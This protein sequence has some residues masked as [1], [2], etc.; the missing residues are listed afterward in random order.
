LVIYQERAL[1]QDFPLLAGLPTTAEPDT[2]SEEDLTSLDAT[3]FS[4]A[5]VFATDWTA[6]TILRQLDKGNISLDP[7]Y[8]R[9]DAWRPDRKSRFIESL[10]LGLPIPQLVLAE[11]KGRK[12]SY[13]VIDGKQRLLSLRQFAAKPAKPDAPY[14]GLSLTGLKIRPELNG[15]TLHDME[16]DP[17][18][19]SEVSAFQ[20]QPIRT[21]VLRNWPDENFLY[22][23]FLRLNTG[24][25]QLSPQ[26]LRQALHPGPFV[27]FSVE[28]S[29]QSKGLQKF[30]RITSPDFRMRDVEM[31]VRFYAFQNFI[32]HYTGNLKVFMDTTCSSLNDQWETAKDL[33]KEQA[34]SMDEAIAATFEI[35]GEDNAFRKSEGVKYQA[36][37]NRAVFDIMVYY[38]T[39]P[40]VRQHA[41]NRKQHV[42]AI[43]RQ[44]CQDPEFVRSLETTTKSIAATQL[45][46]SRWGE[47]LS[48]AIEHPITPPA[49]GQPA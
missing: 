37:R 4:Q 15:K 44:L 28:R 25:V 9:R 42:E 47:A 19:Q 5:V 32:E 39:Q 21:V 12:G 17:S 13:I 16:E 33:L 35:F 38:F 11:A 18:L 10:L 26:E 45:R 30:F 3:A 48:N 7:G 41:L 29:G 20:N 22:L 46:L 23:V 36:R 2:E 43:F 31:L 49:I 1:D 40:D 8:Q 27:S 24:N 34:D 6:E 14:D